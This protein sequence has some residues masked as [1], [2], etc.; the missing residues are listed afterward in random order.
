[1]ARPLLRVVGGRGGPP[2]PPPRAK[3]LT[4]ADLSP[5]A[6]MRRRLAILDHLLELHAHDGAAVIDALQAA[7]D[8]L[9]PASLAEQT[10]TRPERRTT[11]APGFSLDR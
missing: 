6:L 3:T 5:A 10:P 4:S 11:D 1:M 7:R 8:A 2:S 9:V